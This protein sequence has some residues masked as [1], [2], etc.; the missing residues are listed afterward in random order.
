[1]ISKAG[2]SSNSPN[3]ENGVQEDLTRIRA[4]HKVCKQES[5]NGAVELEPT[6]EEDALNSWHTFSVPVYKRH[7]HLFYASKE[8]LLRN[9]VLKESGGQPA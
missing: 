2:H 7:K 4:K 5:S 1:M 9:K 3:H 6:K 8:A